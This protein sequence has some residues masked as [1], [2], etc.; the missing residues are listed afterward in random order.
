MKSYN[1]RILPTA[2]TDI[3]GALNYIANDLSNPTAALKLWKVIS[4]CFTR[5][6]GS[7][8]YGRELETNTPLKYTYRWVMAENYLIFY[9]VNES[10]ETVYIMRMLFGSSNYISILSKDEDN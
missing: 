2:Q 7:P 9:T 5:L 10:L 6:K 4:D 1:V 8:L 3:N